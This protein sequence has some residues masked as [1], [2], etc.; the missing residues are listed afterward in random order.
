MLRCGLFGSRVSYLVG[1]DPSRSLREACYTGDEDVVLE[2]IERGGNVNEVGDVYENMHAICRKRH[3][4]LM[5]AASQGQ[6]GV[7]HILVEAGATID[8]A[9]TDRTVLVVA[10]QMGHLDVVEFLVSCGAEIDKHDGLGTTPLFEAVTKGHIDVVCFLVRNGANANNP[11]ANNAY[12]ITGAVSLGFYDIAKLL[13]DHGAD[14]NQ[15]SYAGTPL[16]IM[17]IQEP[18]DPDDVMGF[19]RVILRCGGNIQKC[20]P[21]HHPLILACQSQKYTQTTIIYTLLRNDVNQIW[22]LH[23]AASAFCIA[24]N[25]ASPRTKKLKKSH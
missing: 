10:A 6:L 18:A 1:I 2:C 24:S 16:S 15:D 25:Q 4:P 22:S 5:L 11:N 19:L 14:P 23:S 9:G 12:P 21:L 7:A 3:T 8:C 17:C 20:H 13:L